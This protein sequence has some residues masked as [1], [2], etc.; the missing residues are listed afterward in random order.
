MANVILLIDL[1]S[2]MAVRFA[3]TMAVLRRA[4]VEGRDVTDEEL[5]AASAAYDTKKAE[6]LGRLDAEEG[7]GG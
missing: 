7:G 5:D 4:H 2:K 1:L 6:I 3:E